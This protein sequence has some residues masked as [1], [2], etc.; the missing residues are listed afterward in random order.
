MAGV[1]PAGSDTEQG[2]SLLGTLTGTKTASTDPKAAKDATV[3]NEANRA[4]AFIQGLNMDENGPVA[5]ALRCFMKYLV[6]P[7]IVVIMFYVWVGQKAYAFYKI[8]PTNIINMVF[9]IAL[10][11]FGGVYFMSIAAVEAFRNFG[12]AQLL[13]ELEMVWEQAL[14]VGVAHE[15]DQ[16]VDANKDGIVDVEQMTMNELVTHKAKMAM[17]AIDKPDRLMKAVQYLLSAW[18]SVIA[19][20]KVQFARTVAI[21]LGI[22][23]ML[24]LPATQV[25]GPI[26]ALLLGKDLQ[27]W[28]APIVMTT[29]KIIAVAIATYIQSIIS[30]FYSGLRGGRIFG[31]YFVQFLADNFGTKL[32]KAIFGDISE[33][34]PFNPDESYLDEILGLP[35]A[36]VGFYFQFTSG[37]AL[38]FPFDIIMLP[39]TIIEWVIRFNVYT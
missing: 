32:P 28:A 10:C 13:V 29:I 22:A 34:K 1:T 6:K 17:I 8:L 2:S 15:K 36:A 26:L 35:L 21:A 7:L 5:T 30:A 16:K 38:E 37:F 25:F 33:E 18:V 9:G 27:H 23:E 39:L 11:F 20:L 24:E 14:L 3:G 31:T 19:T 4:M 12:G